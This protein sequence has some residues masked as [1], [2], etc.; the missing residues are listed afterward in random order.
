MWPRAE[1][2]MKEARPVYACGPRGA[3]RNGA[4]PRRW[5]PLFLGGGPQSNVTRDL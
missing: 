3:Q 4:E 2:D 5:P 1:L